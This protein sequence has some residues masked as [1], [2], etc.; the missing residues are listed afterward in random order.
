MDRECFWCIANN[1]DLHTNEVLTEYEGTPVC[2]EHARRIA[3]YDKQER[4]RRKMERS[5]FLI[6]E[7]KK[8]GVDID[9]SEENFE[10]A[11]D[12]EL[13]KVVRR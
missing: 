1:K 2:L 9:D 8:E 10:E 3:R 11:I 12:R 13:N 5:H 6:K 7:M 4:F